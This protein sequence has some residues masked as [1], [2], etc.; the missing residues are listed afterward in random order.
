MGI[1]GELYSREA[2]EK[3]KENEKDKFLA[4]RWVGGGK[5]Q[6]IYDELW[7]AHSDAERRLKRLYEK[8]HKEAAELNREYDQ[9][10]Q[11]VMDAIAELGTFEREKLGMTNE[12]QEPAE[13]DRADNV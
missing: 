5:D 12:E 13:L 2:Y 10:R 1:F 4:A 11:R 9:L 3:A 8:G 7:G 6:R